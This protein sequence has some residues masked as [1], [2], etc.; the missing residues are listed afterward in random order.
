MTTIP[1]DTTPNAKI[2]VRS[3][4]RITPSWTLSELKTRLEPITGIPASSQF[5][6]TLSID[7]QTWITLSP[8]SALAGDA[9][10]GLTR[11]SEL[12]V[13]DLR[14]PGTRENFSD[15]SNVEKYVMPE[16]QYEKLNDSVLAWKK[17]QH[18]GRF[19]PHAKPLELLVKERKEKDMRV[20]EGKNIGVGMRCQVDGSDERR[21]VV[22]YVGEIEGLGGDREK[23]CVWVGVEFDE[24]VGRNDGSV[25]VEV[26]TESGKRSR[27]KRQVFETK[28]AK[29]GGL[30][31]PEKIEVGDVFMVLDDLVDSDMEE[32]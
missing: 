8:D 17:R 4:R 20:V 7:G 12:Q 29:Y 30:V 5:L 3:E 24:P 16:E 2:L 10:W 15:V 14:P 21:G 26:V 32:I 9:R 11:N 23:G 25:E 31:R 6:R 13:I 22:R 28:G 19:D 1:H 27:E 18:L